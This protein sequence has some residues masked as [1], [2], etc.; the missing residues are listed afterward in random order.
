MD[1]EGTY[2]Y[3]N[4]I[5]N[6]DPKFVGERQHVLFARAHTWLFSELFK[7]LKGSANDAATSQRTA[8]SENAKGWRR[9]NPTLKPETCPFFDNAYELLTELE[10][11]SKVDTTTHKAKAD[12]ARAEI[13]D[14]YFGADAKKKSQI[15]QLSS[16]SFPAF[17]VRVQSALK[18]FQRLL[19]AEEVELENHLSEGGKITLL[20]SFC[21]QRHIQRLHELINEQKRNSGGATFDRTS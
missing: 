7:K 20:T 2:M 18:Q 8:A 5:L 10:T 12:I 13:R 4:P 14:G 9:D 19:K 11:T 17:G 16:E 21:H 3:L 6:G 1:T 15:G